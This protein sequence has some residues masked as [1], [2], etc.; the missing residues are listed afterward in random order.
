MPVAEIFNM[1][2]GGI[3]LRKLRARVSDEPTGFVWIY[4]GQ[5]A[6]SGYPASKGQVAWLSRKGIN[7]ILS[8]T[9]E[10]LPDSWLKSSMNYIHIPMRDHEPPDQASLASGAARIESELA[11][12]KVVLVHCQ[13]GI[14]RTMCAMGAY[15]IK[16]KKRGADEAMDFLREIRPG[17]VEQQQEASLRE[18]A[19]AL[20]RS[21]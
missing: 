9:E 19:A 18:F 3:F 11:S 13:A 16:S 1:G 10:P 4:E 5:L 7:S 12:G 2:K 20:G 6:G 21:S 8:L 14:G 17:A 15:L